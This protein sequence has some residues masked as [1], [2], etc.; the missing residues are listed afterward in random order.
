MQAKMSASKF[1]RKNGAQGRAE[2]V[3]PLQLLILSHFAFVSHC[4]PR[5]IFNIVP[6]DFEAP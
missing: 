4:L 1:G 2:T 5:R 6:P 3:A